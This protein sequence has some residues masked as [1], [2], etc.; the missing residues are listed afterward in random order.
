M[1]R[2]I[3]VDTTKKNPVPPVYFPARV[4]APSLRYEKKLLILFELIN[5]SPPVTKITSKNSATN[6]KRITKF[7]PKKKVLRPPHL[8]INIT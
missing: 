3:T 2:S 7:R 5:A 1:I 4:I 6:I 8:E